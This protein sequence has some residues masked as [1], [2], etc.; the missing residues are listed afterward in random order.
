ME[1][2]GPALSSKWHHTGVSCSF[3][4]SHLFFSN[5]VSE[6]GL[7]SCFFFFFCFVLLSGVKKENQEC[8]NSVQTHNTDSWHGDPIRSYL[9]GAELSSSDWNSSAAFCFC[10]TIKCVLV[11][12][13]SMHTTFCTQIS[14]KKQNSRGVGDDSCKSLRV[15]YFCGALCP[16]LLSVLF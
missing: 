13:Y 12:M 6:L 8:G 5:W 10:H 11:H 7:L 15:K 16:K 2:S 3:P 1:S 9:W 14:L 4:L